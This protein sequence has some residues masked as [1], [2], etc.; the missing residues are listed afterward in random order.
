[1][2]SMDGYLS[3]VVMHEICHGIGPAFART[4]QGRVDIRE[5]IGPIQSAS[6]KPRPTSSGC[7]RSSG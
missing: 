6:K 1:M 7:S 3:M 5:A 2:A 4:A